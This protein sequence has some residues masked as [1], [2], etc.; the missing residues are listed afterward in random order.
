[1]WDTY[2]QTA[3]ENMNNEKSLEQLFNQADEIM[4]KPLYDDEPTPTGY[5]PPYAHLTMDEACKQFEEDAE[6]E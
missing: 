2:K 1:M 5:V 4:A 6:L 3:K